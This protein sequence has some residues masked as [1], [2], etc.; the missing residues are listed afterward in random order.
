[1][2][3]L[4]RACTSGHARKARPQTGCR[5]APTR[6][7]ARLAPDLVSLLQHHGQPLDPNLVRLAE[8]WTEA[9]RQLAAAGRK[10]PEAEG[11]GEE[12]EEAEGDG[13]GGAD[14]APED[15]QVGGG[16]ACCFRWGL[17]HAAAFAPFQLGVAAGCVPAFA[18]AAGSLPA[19]KGIGGGRRC[20]LR[21]SWAP[22][23]PPRIR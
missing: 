16:V 8:A 23:G 11:E 21:W 9:E 22:H 2:F 15:L 14:A 19:G 7:Q 18:A 4:L 17:G 5:A 10:L 13:G 3:G 1:M 20:A 12:E 6:K